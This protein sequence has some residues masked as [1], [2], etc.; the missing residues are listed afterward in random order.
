MY[1]NPY[2]HTYHTGTSR[3]KPAPE[4]VIVNNEIIKV[5][6]ESTN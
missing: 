3:L 1:I 2:D 6:V 4:S 5:W